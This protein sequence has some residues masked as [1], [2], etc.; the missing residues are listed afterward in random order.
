MNNPTPT[1]YRVALIGCGRIGSLLEDDPLRGRPCTHAG[2]FHSHDGFRLIAGCDLNAERLA[3]FGERWGVK[4]EHLYGDYQ[5]LLARE[6]PDV[7]SVATWT[8]THG[9]LVEAAAQAGVRA[10]FCEKPLEATVAKAERMVALCRERG[11]HLLVNH[12]RRWAWQYRNARALLASGELG[13]VR[14][15]NGCVLTGPPLADW[16]SDPTRVGAG[17]LLHDGTHLVDAIRFLVG[18]E[19]RAVGGNTYAEPGWNVEHT[20]AAWFRMGAGVEGFL[21]AGG[22]RGYFHFEID[23]QTSRGRLQI[24]NGFQRVYRARD[25][26]LYSGFRDL[27]EA[28]FPDHDRQPRYSRAMTELA[29]A[30]RG[31]PELSSTGDDG[32]AVMR[33]IDGIYRSARRG[34][35]L[36]EL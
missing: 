32:L 9:A 11:V 7:V 14:I 5:E 19:Y 4:P 26:R 8:G 2:A 15:V 12:D 34:G 27:V 30:L 29:A 21:E 23:V 17:P 20:A 35:A 28:P 6:Q 13:E 10:I 33:A 31:A 25:S 1:R 18:D 24:G 3:R 22:R 16:H 36:V